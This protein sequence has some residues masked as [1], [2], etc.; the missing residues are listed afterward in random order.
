MK[1]LKRKRKMLLLRKNIKCRQGTFHFANH[2]D[3]CK[4]L[5]WTSEYSWIKYIYVIDWARSINKML[6]FAD[7]AP[8][9]IINLGIVA[10][11]TIFPIDQCPMMMLRYIHWYWW[12]DG[13]PCGWTI[14]LGLTFGY[15]K[16][17]K[18]KTVWTYRYYSKI[19]YFYIIANFF[20]QNVKLSEI[21]SRAQMYK[22]G[23]RHY[24]TL[25]TRTRYIVHPPKFLQL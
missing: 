6:H 17:V 5:R 11:Y 13:V 4:I 20:Y 9:H 12:S 8:W 19:Q 3:F 2:I 21:K 1:L 22:D 14:N 24:A 25:D 15:K 18:K 7:G 10:L 16:R 23:L